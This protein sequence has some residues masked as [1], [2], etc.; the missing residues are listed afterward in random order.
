MLNHLGFKQ[1]AENH[2]GGKDISAYV[3][4]LERLEGNTVGLR[5]HAT[6][7]F[8]SKFLLGKTLSRKVKCISFNVIDKGMPEH[9]PK[10]RAN[11]NIFYF[12]PANKVNFQFVILFK[13]QDNELVFVL[14]F[15]E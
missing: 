13:C 10:V 6:T 12:N 7:P 1:D 14:F 2:G 5:Y 3:A 11:S 15:K 4:I 9:V 8:D